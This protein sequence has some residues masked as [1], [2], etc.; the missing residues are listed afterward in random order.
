[1]LTSELKYTYMGQ[2]RGE[3]ETGTLAE[4]N[5]KPGDVVEC[6]KAGDDRWFYGVGSKDKVSAYGG[7]LGI[8]SIFLH[9]VKGTFRIISRA[10][11]GPVREVNVVRKEI[12]P[13]SYGHIWVERADN[14]M[15]MVM[16][17]M[18]NNALKKLPSV[19]LSAAELTA[20]IA[21]LTEIRDAMEADHA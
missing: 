7:W 3:P 4:L 19:G 5:V 17:G 11:D 8:G 12:V 16:L 1:M 20:A 2:G 10:S 9:E 18:R 6:V 15:G 13:G 14:G 21:T